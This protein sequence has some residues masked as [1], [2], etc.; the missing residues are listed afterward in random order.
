MFKV[1][2]F[3]QFLSA[4]K[5]LYFPVFSSLIEEKRERKIL[6]EINKSTINRLTWGY[7]YCRIYGDHKT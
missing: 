7:R 5:F 3:Y 1:T 4:Q 6:I 2:P